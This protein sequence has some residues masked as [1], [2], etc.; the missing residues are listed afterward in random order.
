MYDVIVPSLGNVASCLTLSHACCAAH[1]CRILLTGKRLIRIVR[2][3]PTVT[4]LV[5]S[6][7][8]EE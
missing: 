6:I 8:S 5:Y 3:N 1:E 7:T 4:V 2:S